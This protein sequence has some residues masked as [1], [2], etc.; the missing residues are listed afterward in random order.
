MRQVI[1]NLLTTIIHGI[2]QDGISIMVG[3]DIQLEKDLH[4]SI[5]RQL[6]QT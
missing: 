1:L 3:L 4:L 6:S 5:K 2:P